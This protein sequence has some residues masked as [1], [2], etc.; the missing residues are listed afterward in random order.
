V[1]LFTIR[2]LF[3]TMSVQFKS[4]SPST[5]PT[6]KEENAVPTEDKREAI[7]RPKQVNTML[8]P[9]MLSAWPS[10]LCFQFAM[11]SK[12]KSSHPVYHV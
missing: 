5:A 4:A 6:K 11:L 7:S 10:L 9:A 12:K 1:D 2:G 8:I 3:I